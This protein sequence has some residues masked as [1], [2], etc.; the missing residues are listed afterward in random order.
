MLGLFGEGIMKVLGIEKQTNSKFLNLYKITYDNG[1]SWLIASRRSEKELMAVTSRVDVDTVTIIP[2]I[3]DKDGKEYVMLTKEFRYSLNANVWSFP[4]GLV[5]KGENPELAARRELE[6]ETGAAEVENMQKITP[7]CLKSEGMT[8]ETAI[9]FKANVILVKEQNLQDSES[10]D[11]VYVPIEKIPN[12]TAELE[13]NGECFSLL[14][15]AY[16]PSIYNEH[17]L[18]ERIRELEEENEILKE[19]MKNPNGVGK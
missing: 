7:T 1:V 11:V 17:M 2:V 19:G 16:L 14:A 6:E 8:D 9:I 18:N 5:E 10:I 13:K 4:S 3:K 15:A 12:F